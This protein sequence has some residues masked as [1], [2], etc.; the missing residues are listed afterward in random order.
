MRFEVMADIEWP[1]DGDEDPD[2]LYCKKRAT[3]QHRDPDACEFIIHAGINMGDVP[4]YKDILEE[5]KEAGCS[6]GFMHEY[7]KAAEE[8]AIR[9]LFYC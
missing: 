2:W 6:K 5:M 3:F 9:I 1:F 7:R 4:Y 8:G